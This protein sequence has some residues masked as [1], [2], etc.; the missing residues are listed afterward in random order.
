M[1]LGPLDVVDWH[2]VN[3]GTNV[4][5]D[6]Y[7]VRGRLKSVLLLYILNISVFLKCNCGCICLLHTSTDN[8]MCTYM[9]R[10]SHDFNNHA[11]G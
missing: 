10:R 4:H 8:A 2:I 7:I 6:F 3:R 9:L 5:F 1:G 11:S